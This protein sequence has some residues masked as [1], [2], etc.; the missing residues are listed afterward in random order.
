MALHED[1]IIPQGKSWVGPMWA[2][3]GPND[4]PYDLA[5][6]TVR[7]QVRESPRSPTVLHEWSTDDETIAIFTGVTVELDDGTTVNTAAV[8]LT[9]K[10]AESTAWGWR[11]GVYDVEV[12]EDPETVWPIVDPSSVRVTQEVTR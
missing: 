6:K 8:A 4:E 10:P 5:G 2:L 1:L 7:A 12:E 3:L 9:V 11:V